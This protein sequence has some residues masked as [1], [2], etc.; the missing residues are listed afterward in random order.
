MSKK[1]KPARAGLGIIP[2]SVVLSVG[3]A[4]WLAAYFSTLPKW[5]ATAAAVVVGLVWMADYQLRALSTLAEHKRRERVRNVAIAAGLALLVAI[6]Y[7]ATMVRL[8]PNVFN[9]PY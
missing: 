1:P 7:A 9:R 4:V 6:F 5:M 2:R 8:G 3:V